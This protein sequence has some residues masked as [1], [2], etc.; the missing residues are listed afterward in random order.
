MIAVF[1]MRII[2][3]LAVVAIAAQIGPIAAVVLAAAEP[4]EY[5]RIMDEAH[6]SITAFGGTFLMM[7][8]LSYFIDE[9]KEVHWIAVLEARLRRWASI[10]GLEITAV[11]LVVLGFSAAL[12]SA[13]SATF[14]FSAIFGLV[15]FTAVEALGQVLDA[16]DGRLC[17]PPGGLG[18]VPL[19]RSARRELL[20]RRGDRRLRADPKPFSL[21]SASALAR[22]TCGP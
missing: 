22:C 10:R 11:L 7:V 21:R 1:G 19:S 8:A 9:G 16:A 20:L 3:P 5:A 13:E 12:P 17:R 4:Q 2:F 18:R 6:L 14:L 15:V